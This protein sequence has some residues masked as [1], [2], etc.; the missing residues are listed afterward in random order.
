MP[1]VAILIIVFF[2]LA[3]LASVLV[4]AAS[5]LGTSKGRQIEPESEVWSDGH[6][7]H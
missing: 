4:I 6:D 7:R 1:L 5:I 2:A 3:F